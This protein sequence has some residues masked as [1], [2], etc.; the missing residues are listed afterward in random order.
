MATIRGWR[1]NG[2]PEA[3]PEDPLRPSRASTG[4]VGAGSPAL[5]SYAS[6]IKKNLYGVTIANRLVTGDIDFAD[7]CSDLVIRNCLVQGQIKVRECTNVLIEYCDATGFIIDGAHNIELRYC[8]ATGEL[9]VDGMQ[10]KADGGAVPTN[11]WV[12]HNYLGNAVVNA[13][14]HYDGVQVRGVEGLR[15]E[16]NYLDP[17]DTFSDRQNAAIFLQNANGGN[18]NVVVN[19]NWIKA[20][21]HGVL[22][23]SVANTA[24]FTNNTFYEGPHSGK[25]V[26]ALS[27]TIVQSGNKWDDGTP[28]PDITVV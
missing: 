15:F 17:A 21:G 16:Y 13:S 7:G 8:Y 28:I 10:I 9:G 27:G 4:Y 5:T 20:M 18:W 12:H 14:S 11:V 25:L 19:N 1:L 24:E 2:V 23:I 26:K 3:P 6:G 22:S